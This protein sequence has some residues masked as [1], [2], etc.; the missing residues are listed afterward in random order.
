MVKITVQPTTEVVIHDIISVD[1]NDLLRER[2][3]PQGT[4]P[5][6]WC[7]GVLFSFSS[8][9]MTE[10]V[11]RDYMHGKLHWIEVHFAAMQSYQPILI[12]DDEEYKATMK[13]RVIDTSKSELH[14]DLTKWLKANVKSKQK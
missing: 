11:A 13:I 1:V 2:I 6:Y 8:M 14:N 3:T 4:M 10:D 9:P 12:L 5:L 7:N